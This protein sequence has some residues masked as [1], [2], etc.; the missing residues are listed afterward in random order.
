M[1]I[2]DLEF[3]SNAVSLLLCLAVSD[4]PSAC[5]S[6]SLEL[7]PSRYPC[8]PLFL[9]LSQPLFSELGTGSDEL[10]TFP[11]VN[12]QTP[13]LAPPALPLGSMRGWGGGAGGS[14]ACSGHPPAL[15]QCCSCSSKF[16]GLRMGERE[17]GS[18]TA[19]ADLLDRWAQ[20]RVHQ[21]S[22]SPGYAGY[23]QLAPKQTSEEAPPPH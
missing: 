2:F 13:P 6:D 4:S 19:H 18:A 21:L 14:A 7:S 9:S 23:S 17:G 8:L 11:V 1:C 22:G 20:P 5:F 12:T 15:P 3:L 10:H 16:W